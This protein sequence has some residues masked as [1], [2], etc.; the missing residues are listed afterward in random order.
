MVFYWN[1]E[2]PKDVLLFYVAGRADESLVRSVGEMIDRLAQERAW[3]ISPP[4]FVDQ[5]EEMID[6]ETGRPV[7]TVG[8]LLEMYT[9][10]GEWRRELP[11]EVDAAHFEECQS[12][13]SRVADLS[14]ASGAEFHFEFQGELVGVIQGG[15]ADERLA[16]QFLGTWAIA[17]GRREK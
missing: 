17:V 1:S 8:G 14:R 15:E 5:E 3:V 2:H 16:E 11:A 10:H 7:R 9:A 12:V 13:V 4:Y 6:P